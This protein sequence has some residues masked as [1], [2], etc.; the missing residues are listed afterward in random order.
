[1]RLKRCGRAKLVLPATIL[2]GE[3]GGLPGG[4]GVGVHEE[5]ETKHNVSFTKLNIMFIKSVK[6]I[7]DQTYI[8][9]EELIWS[10]YWRRLIWSLKKTH[11]INN[12]FYSQSVSVGITDKFISD[13]TY[14]F[15]EDSF[16]HWRRLIWSIIFSVLTQLALESL[17]IHSAWHSFSFISVTET[18]IRSVHSPHPLVHQ[19]VVDSVVSDPRSFRTSP[20]PCYAFAWQFL[21]IQRATKKIAFVCCTQ[22][23]PQAST[24]WSASSISPLLQ[25]SRYTVR[26]EL[27][28]CSRLSEAT[29]EAAQCNQHSFSD[30]ARVFSTPE[31]EWM[32]GSSSTTDA[33]PSL[34][35]DCLLIP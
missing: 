8:F 29:L 31:P 22:R 12:I 19:N 1:M 25:P 16:D 6:F 30:K 17:I 34:W 18:T 21:S 9:E 33:V 28:R 14:N 5:R 15:G 3:N 13:Q 27:C 26:N 4:W 20:Q 11:L 23:S 10:Y 2:R 7:S 35:R 32:R 24:V